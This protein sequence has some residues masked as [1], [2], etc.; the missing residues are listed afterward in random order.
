MDVS[1][2]EFEE[3]VEIQLTELGGKFCFRCH[4]IK[5]TSVCF[6]FLLNSSHEL[7]FGQKATFLHWDKPTGIKSAC[8]IICSAKISMS[9]PVFSIVAQII[10]E[11]IT[12][13]D[14]IKD[15]ID[16]CIETFKM[17]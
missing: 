3:Y 14:K 2:A 9:L 10:D 5:Y 1:S 16:H 13:K 15:I 6:S 4:N 8:W 12:S 17:M 7:H 11:A